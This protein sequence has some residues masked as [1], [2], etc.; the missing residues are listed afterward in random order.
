MLYMSKHEARFACR[1]LSY[2]P[3]EAIL[4]YHIYNLEDCQTKFP[5]LL[6]EVFQWNRYPTN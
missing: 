2:P 1:S 6:K 3:L 5:F 4:G